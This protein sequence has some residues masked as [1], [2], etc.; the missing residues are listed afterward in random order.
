MHTIARHRLTYD[1]ATRAYAERR[2][3]PRQDRPRNP[4][5]P[6]ALHHPPGLPPAHPRH[7]PRRLTRR[8]TDQLTLSGPCRRWTGELIR[9]LP[10]ETR[11]LPPDV[12]ARCIGYAV[13]RSA[14]THTMGRRDRNARFEG[15]S[16]DRAHPRSARSAT[17]ADQPVARCRDGRRHGRRLGHGARV[18]PARRLLLGHPR[19]HAVRV[20]RHA[21]RAD[22]PAPRGLQHLGRLPGQHD[23]PG[24]RLRHLRVHRPLVRRAGELAAR[25]S[26]RRSTASPPAA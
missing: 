23:G 14:D 22:R 7:D 1:P 24:G 3:R 26:V 21:R 12:S 8:F 25:S 10:D 2:S 15:A 16:A 4:P 5:L 20:L 19:D 9:S 13:D 17:G 18:L 11:G 6:Q